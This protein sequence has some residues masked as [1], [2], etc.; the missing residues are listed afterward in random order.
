MLL[1]DDNH[2]QLCK[3]YGVL[4]DG[5]GAYKNLDATV[6]QAFEHLLASFALDDTGQQ[7]HSD[8]HSFQKVGDGLQVLFGENLRRCHDTRLIT[9]V[10]GDEHRHQGH[11][12]LSAAHIALQQTVHLSTR[13]HILADLPD[14]A[15]LGF[16]E[17]K[18]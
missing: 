5:V 13:A 15:L 1:I 16:C 7:F 12:C 9:V 10:E 18:G 3:L 4:D 8:I 17:R 14:D 2:S 11:Q 6:E